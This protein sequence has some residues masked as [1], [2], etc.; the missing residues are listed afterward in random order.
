[1]WLWGLRAYPPLPG[2]L[3]W[4]ATG[5]KAKKGGRVVWCPAGLL[6]PLPLLRL[7]PCPVLGCRRGRGGPVHPWHC[8]CFAGE[9]RGGPRDEIRPGRPQSDPLGEKGL[10]LRA[11][12]TPEVCADRG[13]CPGLRDL[14]R[15]PF[16]TAGQEPTL[17]EDPLQADGSSQRPPPTS[18]QAGS[19]GAEAVPSPA[20]ENVAAGWRGQRSP[21]PGLLGRQP[22]AGPLCPRAGRAHPDTSGSLRLSGSGPWACFTRP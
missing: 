2:A 3:G 12:P 5:T 18:S 16:P 11:D 20:G 14:G 6:R 9:L 4:V 22:A 21:A 1:M 13:W 19:A 8:W 17:R 15:G 7:L 10:G